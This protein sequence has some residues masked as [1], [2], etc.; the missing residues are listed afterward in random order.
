MVLWGRSVLECQK[1]RLWLPKG[2]VE[3]STKFS[4]RLHQ[5]FTKVAQV[6]WSLWSS[7][8]DPFRFRKGS[9]D[10]SPHHFSTFLSQLLQLIFAFFSTV[11]AFGSS[12]IIKVLGKLHI[13]LLKFFAQ[14]AFASQKVLWSVP[15]TVLYIRLRISRGFSGKWLLL[16]K[17]FCEGSPNYSLHLTPKRLLLHKKFVG[18]FRQLRFTFISQSPPG[19][20]VAWIV[21][22]SQPQPY[23]S[24]PQKPTDHVVAVGVFFGIRF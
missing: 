12:A 1:V 15:Q 9:A 22:M 14:M 23:K 2:S 4:R 3:G 21:D 17:R 24:S 8:A 13:C 5:G 10:S 11:L 7:G 19:V 18:E 20:K 16:Q 6:S